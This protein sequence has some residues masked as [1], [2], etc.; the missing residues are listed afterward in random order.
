MINSL[1]DKQDFLEIFN[2]LSDG[3]VVYDSKLR[4][5]FANE[6][7]YEYAGLDKDTLL[8]TTPDMHLK[9]GLILN[10]I[11]QQ[12]LDHKR[13]ITGMVQARSGYY[14]SRC[15]P[16]FDKE[17]NVQYVVST[18]SSLNEISALKEMLHHQSEKNELYLREVEQLRRA[19]LTDKYIFVSKHMEKLSETI[20]KVAPIDCNV[21]ITG[22]SDLMWSPSM[23]NP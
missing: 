22:E 5:V 10:S 9:D 17:G 11:V 15:R 3:V 16:V 23:L 7:L 2:S 20:K 6:K 18:A 8:G 19:L 12:V 4:V 13:E 1:L 21:L 14:S